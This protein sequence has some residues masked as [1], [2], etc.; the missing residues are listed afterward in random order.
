MKLAN[1]LMYVVRGNPVTYYGDEQG[2]IG[3]GGDQLAREDMFASKVDIYNNET[4]LAT[5]SGSKDR[6]STSAVLYKQLKELAALRAKHPALADGAQI[7][8]ARTV[9][10]AIPTMTRARSQSWYLACDAKM[11]AWRATMTAARVVSPPMA[12]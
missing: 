11:T 3:T 1:A 5:A 6:Y 4:M 8:R 2:F 12:P 10:V 7:M 9:M